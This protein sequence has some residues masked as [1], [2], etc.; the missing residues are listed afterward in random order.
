MDIIK[1]NKENTITTI[2]KK[3][4]AKKIVNEHKVKLIKIYQLKV[5]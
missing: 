1:M 3:K 4:T 2:P 5:M